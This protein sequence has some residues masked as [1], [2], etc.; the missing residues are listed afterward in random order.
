MPSNKN[1]RMIRRNET[2]IVV[3]NVGELSNFHEFNKNFDSSFQAAMLR[4]LQVFYRL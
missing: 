2:Y 1:T 4:R 3:I